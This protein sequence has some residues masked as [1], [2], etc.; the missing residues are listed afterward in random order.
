L[1]DELLELERLLAAKRALVASRAAEA[2]AWRREGARSPESWLARKAGST[3]AAARGS[4]EAVANASA[5][6]HVEDA[7]RRGALSPTQAELVADAAKANPSAVGELL[8]AAR[9]ESV[10]EL[11]RRAERVKAAVRSADD[12]QRRHEQIRRARCLRATVRDGVFELFAKG[13]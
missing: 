9:Q 6:P 3:V 13:R 5:V 10:A 11:R 1:L 12:E 7:L 4:M 8:D 2:G